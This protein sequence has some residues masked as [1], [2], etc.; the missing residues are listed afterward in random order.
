[1]VNLE[2]KQRRSSITQYLRWHGEFRCVSLSFDVFRCLSLPFDAFRCI[3]LS[4]DVLNFRTSG[5]TAN[6]SNDSL[7]RSG[8]RVGVSIANDRFFRQSRLQTFDKKIQNYETKFVC[9]L[10]TNSSWSIR[11]CN[12]L[13]ISAWRIVR[14]HVKIC[15]GNC[16]LKRLGSPF[17][18]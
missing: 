4:F 13:L 12:W 17:I 14:L 1:M 3:S 15:S 7:C 18:C 16:S 2:R 10:R 5:S 11:G 9:S 8:N 6:S